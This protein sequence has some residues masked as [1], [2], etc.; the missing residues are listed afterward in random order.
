MNDARVNR[1]GLRQAGQQNPLVRRVRVAAGGAET[2]QRGDAR[3]DQHVAFVAGA[4]PRER[5]GFAVVYACVIL[6]DSRQ[7]VIQRNSRTGDIHL[8]DDLGFQSGALLFHRAHDLGHAFLHGPAVLAGQQADVDDGAGGF[9]YDA[10]VHPAVEDGAGRDGE[11]QVLETGNRR[12]L[13]LQLLSRSRI[14]AR[15]VTAFRPLVFWC[16]ASMPAWMDSPLVRISSRSRPRWPM[17]TMSL[18]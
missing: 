14:S 6:R 13:D 17:H 5:P 8:L 7:R 16:Q 11:A 12:R 9:G 3:A 4:G 1:D 15:A 18:V 10:L 2:A